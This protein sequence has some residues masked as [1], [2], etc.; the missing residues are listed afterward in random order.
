MER[1]IADNHIERRVNA[2]NSTIGGMIA[3]VANK[4]V[5]TLR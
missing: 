1:L 3:V 4:K 2:G 5:S